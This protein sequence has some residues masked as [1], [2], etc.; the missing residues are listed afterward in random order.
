MQGFC[1]EMPAAGSS[2]HPEPE[3][4][5]TFLYSPS[6]NTP[7]QNRLY[8]GTLLSYFPLGS[9]SGVSQ[10]VQAQTGHWEDGK[11]FL[12][13][14]EYLSP[15]LY[16]QGTAGKRMSPWKDS[17]DNTTTGCG[18]HHVGYCERN[19]QSSFIQLC[20]CIYLCI[21]TYIY[22]DILLLLAI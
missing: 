9:T 7:V 8:R 10:C 17:Q 22:I 6:S 4:H 19:H 2:T 20:T 1:S 16:L 3:Q 14:A 18:W 15:F 12:S 13:T 5:N 21:N 11:G